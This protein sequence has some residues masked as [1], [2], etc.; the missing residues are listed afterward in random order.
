M[1]LTC[2]ILIPSLAEIQVNAFYGKVKK[3]S[4]REYKLQDRMQTHGPRIEVFLSLSLEARSEFSDIYQAA[5][6]ELSVSGVG[7]PLITPRSIIREPKV[8]YSFA[9][10]PATL[11]KSNGSNGCGRAEKIKNV[12]K[13]HQV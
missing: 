2:S 3:T 11:R 6:S 12:R 10:R 8:L 5:S 13:Q 1:V 7:R 4:I 9:A